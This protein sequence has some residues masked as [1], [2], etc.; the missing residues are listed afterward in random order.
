LFEDLIEMLFINCALEIVYVICKT[1]P[2]YFVQIS[3]VILKLELLCF[4]C[5]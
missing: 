5:T 3:F 4:G 2:L 1:S